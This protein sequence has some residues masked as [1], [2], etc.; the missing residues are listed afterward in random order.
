MVTYEQLYAEN[1]KLTELSNVLDYLMRD[2]PMLDTSTTCGLF[3]DYFDRVTQHLNEVDNNLYQP[4]LVSDAES[5]KVA[6]EFMSGS[7]EIKRVIKQYMRK[8]CDKKHEALKVK[9]HEQ[10]VDDTRKIFELVL[11]R[12]QDETEHLY[13]MVRH[14]TGDKLAA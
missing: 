1:H 2:R 6:N 4:L 12:T 10:F 5:K 3:Y 14:V 13:P 9:D 7:Q 8:W 11:M